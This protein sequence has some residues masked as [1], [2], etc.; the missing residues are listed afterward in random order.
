M[1]AE[2]NFAPEE[3]VS[4]RTHDILESTCDFQFMEDL[5]EERATSVFGT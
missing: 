5:S 1:C 4:L 2:E 3:T